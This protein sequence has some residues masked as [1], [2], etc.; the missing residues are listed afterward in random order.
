M[1][2]SIRLFLTR[3]SKAR[4][5]HSEHH[6]LASQRF[7]IDLQ[8]WLWLRHPVVSHSIL[9]STSPLP[10]DLLVRRRRDYCELFRQSLP[11]LRATLVLVT[12]KLQ[13]HWP[14]KSVHV[15]STNNPLTGRNPKALNFLHEP[16]E[17][18][19]CRVSCQEPMSWLFQASAKICG[20]IQDLVC[21][22]SDAKVRY[23]YMRR[24]CYLI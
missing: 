12:S 17:S 22:T 23:R 5:S 4:H 3:L 19:R 1:P 20:A 7:R 24:R 21:T 2:L 16:K 10:S 6:G 13:Q 8:V 15:E 14:P 11:Q 9:G 18:C